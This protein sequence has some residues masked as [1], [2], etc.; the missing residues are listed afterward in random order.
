[1]SDEAGRLAAAGLGAVCVFQLGLTAGMPW[2]AAA[3]GGQHR[4]RLPAHLR[5]GSAVSAGVL[6]TVAVLAA[7]GPRPAEPWR[8]RTLTAGSLL[9]G[10]GVPMNLASPSPPE[11]LWAPFAAAVSVLL[12]RTARAGTPRAQPRG[13]PST[14]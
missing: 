14:Q 13:R 11:R 2:G 12:W 5:L 6:G 8:A 7:T 10:A 1:M 4:G 9:L 3:W